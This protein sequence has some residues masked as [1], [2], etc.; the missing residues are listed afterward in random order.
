MSP[1]QMLER[2]EELFP[3]FKHALSDWLNTPEMIADCRLLSPAPVTNAS[4]AAAVVMAEL[5]RQLQKTH[6]VKVVK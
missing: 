3:K 4:D 2:F 5:W 6:R 1:E